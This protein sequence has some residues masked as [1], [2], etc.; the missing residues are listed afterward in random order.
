[1]TE[2]QKEDLWQE[3]QTWLAQFDQDEKEV[4]QRVDNGKDFI[5]VQEELLEKLPDGYPFE[6]AIQDIHT[7]EKWYRV[8]LPEE[9]QGI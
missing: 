4:H 8:D 1:M 3:R 7:E 9:Y 2:D 5:F 6:F